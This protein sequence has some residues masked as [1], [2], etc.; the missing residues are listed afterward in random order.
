L[1]PVKIGYAGTSTRKQEA[2][3]A[4]QLRTLLEQNGC[5]EIFQEQVSGAEE[6]AQLNV[7]IRCLRPG[8]QLV[9]T[10]LD[11]FARSLEHAIKLER[12]I[13]AKGASLVILDPAVDT[14]TSIGRLMFNM[15]GAIAQFE[16]EIMLDRQRDGIAAAQAAGKYVGRQPTARR[17][18][19][20]KVK[21]SPQP[22]ERVDSPFGR[23]EG[24]ALPRMPPESAGKPTARSPR[25]SPHSTPETRRS[26]YPALLRP[27]LSVGGKALER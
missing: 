22:R 15:I 18:S 12:C 8:D 24:A 1:T 11:R 14:S 5:E 27:R 23:R 10:K 25:P 19:S 9:V 21:L 7:A 4:A 26:S 3:L 2:G 16:R 6:R 13:A 20:T 17:N